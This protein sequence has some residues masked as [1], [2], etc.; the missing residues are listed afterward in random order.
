[1]DRTGAFCTICV[2]MEQ[3]REEDVVD[4]FHT[5]KHLRTQRPHM[6]Q[7]LVGWKLY[8]SNSDTLAQNICERASQGCIN[9]LFKKLGK[10]FDTVADHYQIS[11]MSEG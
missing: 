2:A 11:F 4:I 5:V 3:A 6:V 9:K 8:C 10:C 7:A 1:M